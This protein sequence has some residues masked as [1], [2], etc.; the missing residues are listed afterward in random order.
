MAGERR[1][2]MDDI[3]LAIG[4]L[5][6]EAKASNVQRVEL[7]KQVGDI[8]GDISDIKQMLLAHNTRVTS[9]LEANA[10]KLVDVEDDVKTLKAF[11]FRVLVGL[12]AIGGL[13]GISGA[14]AAKTHACRVSHVERTE[15]RRVN[16]VANETGARQRRRTHASANE[17]CMPAPLPLTAK[18]R[19]V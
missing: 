7:F 11:R 12:A 13:G 9:M 19:C 3:S 2:G 15:R 17:R 18:R 6:A 16:A 4:E 8:K 1:E 5:R 14:I 10:E